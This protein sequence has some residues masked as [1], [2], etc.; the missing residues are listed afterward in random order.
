MAF[1]SGDR[2]ETLHNQE[3]NPSR[4]PAVDQL[5]ALRDRAVEMAAAVQA[6]DPDAGELAAAFALAVGEAM[7]PANRL[8]AAVMAGGP[9]AVRRALEL[10]EMML[11]AADAVHPR[12]GSAS[13]NDKTGT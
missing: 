4:G 8:V 6:G 3:V 9:F 11:G 1:G 10:G 13:G 2:A 12:T 7:E 5:L